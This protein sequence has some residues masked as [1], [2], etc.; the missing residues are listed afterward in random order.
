MLHR[1]VAISGDLGSGKSTV[2]SLVARQTDR[3]VV[4]TGAMQRSIAAAKGVS[5]LQANLDAEVDES[6]DAQIDDMLR[7]EGLNG[8]PTVFDSR[9]AWHFVPDALTVHLVVSPDVG[10]ERIQGR[11]GSIAE[12]YADASIAFSALN[13]RVTSERQRFKTKYQVDISRLRN[14]HVVVDSSDASPVEIAALI[15]EVLNGEREQGLWISPR[16]VIPTGNCIRMLAPDDMP[17]LTEDPE[18]SF[19][20][21]AQPFFFAARNYQELSSAIKSGRSLVPAGLEAEGEDV[22][23]GGLSAVEYMRSETSLSWLYDWE[24][25]HGFRFTQYPITMDASR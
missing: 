3:R 11:S 18:G 20:C 4:S 17:P 2:A 23:A 15:I 6:I 10:V 25:F 5:T 16:R 22:I 21:Y 24:D 19:V 8:P 14:Y 13:A 1:H 7:R 12:N 9:L